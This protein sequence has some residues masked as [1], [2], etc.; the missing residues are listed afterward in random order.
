MSRDDVLFSGPL[1]QDRAQHPRTS[2]EGHTQGVAMCVSRFVSCGAAGRKQEQAD[3]R[4]SGSRPPKWREKGDLET[5]GCTPPAV[6]APSPLTGRLSGGAA[7]PAV[8][9]GPAGGRGRPFLPRVLGAP[10]SVLSG[11]GFPGASARTS[12]F[13]AGDPARPACRSGRRRGTGAV[14]VADE[15]PPFPEDPA[16]GARALISPFGPRRKQPRE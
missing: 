16:H 9:A 4:A 8:R 12:T 2:P 6:R 15:E 14:G 7:G 11:L 1:P 3:S 5:P 10:A 13:P